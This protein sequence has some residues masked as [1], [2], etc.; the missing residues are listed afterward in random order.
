M[1]ECPRYLYGLACGL[2]CAALVVL[3]GRMDRQTTAVFLIWPCIAAAVVGLR[4]P[5]AVASLDD[6]QEAEQEIRQCELDIDF[7]AQ[8][9]RN[10]HDLLQEDPKAAL[11]EVEYLIDELEGNNWTPARG[12][13]LM[14]GQ[15]A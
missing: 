9:L 8:S 14:G 13:T 15:N 2:L 5:D 12:L 3:Y 10:V 4:R 1:P 11:Y 6:L 7:A